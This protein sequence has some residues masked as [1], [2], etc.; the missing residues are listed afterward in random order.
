LRT[1][2]VSPARLLKW[3]YSPSLLFA[4]I[5]TF[6]GVVF[7]LGALYKLGIGARSDLYYASIIIPTLLYSLVF[8]ALNSVL[9]PMF[10][11]ARVDGKDEDT[12]LMWNCMI[13]T[14]AG[15][16]ALLAI[17][18]YPVLLIFPFLFRKLIWVDLRQVRGVLL[19][20]SLYNIVYM[21]LTTKNCFLFAVGRPVSAQA[22]VFCGWVASL[23]LLARLGVRENLAL[24]PLC[25][26]V[27]N[28]IALVFPNLEAEAFSYRAG[29]LKP[30]TLSVI[31]RTL[32]IA[33]GTSV[34]WLEPAIDGVIASTLK[35]GSLTVYY[36]FGKV[37]FYIA[38]VI[39]SGYVQ[40]VTKHLAELAG[41]RQWREL[42]RRTNSVAFRAAVVGLALWVCSLLVFLFIGVVDTPFL[43]AYVS[44][45]SQNFSVFLLLL[46]YLFGT[47][48]YV[49]FSNGLYIMSRQRL[50]LLA[51]VVTFPAGIILKL[52]GT[53]ILGLQGLALG[54]SV[55]WIGWAS[56]LTGCFYWAVGQNQSNARSL[57][58]I[59]SYEDPVIE[60]LK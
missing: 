7:Q 34:A 29:L 15:G 19:A 41:S 4:G 46:G 33:G 16:S 14:F 55:Y 9:V 54:T 36:F 31:S 44:K 58:S 35:Q 17:F 12:V 56:L 23:C 53:R 32:P 24:I 51:S 42:R 18:Y 30:Q 22:G 11:E 49:V 40:P 25:L 50:F 3:K 21:A 59:P 60:L 10:V 28:A 43:R 20:F 48:G 38:T 13:I 52:L 26:V 6:C 5:N 37:M 39:A 45:F 2:T 27:G 8:G 57:S 47:L 1:S